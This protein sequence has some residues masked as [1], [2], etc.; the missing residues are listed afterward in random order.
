MNTPLIN[1]G[2]TSVDRVIVPLK[3]VNLPKLFVF[4]DLSFTI[5]G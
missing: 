1:S 4:K 3:D 2:R 5:E